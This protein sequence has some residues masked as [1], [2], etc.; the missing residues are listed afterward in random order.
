M[1]YWDGG[2]IYPHICLSPLQDKPAHYQADPFQWKWDT[3]SFEIWIREALLYQKRSY[4]NIGL[5]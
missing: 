1:I 3:L 4:F 2:G 5:K